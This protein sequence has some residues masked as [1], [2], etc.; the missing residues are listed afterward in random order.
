MDSLQQ[1]L[2]EILSSPEKL[3]EVMKIAGEF[4]GSGGDSE[5]P[6]TNEIE[7]DLP[8]SAAVSQS[9]GGADP[10]S[11]LLSMLGSGQNAAAS[12]PAQNA[13]PGGFGSIDPKLLST[14]MQVLNAFG[15]DDDRVRLLRALKPHLRS[16]RAERI[17][18]A[19]QIL[20]VSTA[21]RAAIHS[22]TGGSES[23]VL[24]I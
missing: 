24:K 17:D 18:R 7:A 3:N 14:V 2:N 4:L 11:A 1:K 6:P 20:R 5:S 16:E 8:A 15:Q 9:T 10:M 13:F 22:L 23:D 19:V 21:I 12:A